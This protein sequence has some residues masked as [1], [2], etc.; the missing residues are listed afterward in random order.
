MRSLSGYGQT[1]P[2]EQI[3]IPFEVDDMIKAVLG[4]ILRCIVKYVAFFA[5]VKKYPNHPHPLSYGDLERF[6]SP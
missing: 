2:V 3:K 1:K 5:S 6:T 4:Y